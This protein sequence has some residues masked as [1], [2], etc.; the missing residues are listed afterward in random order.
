VPA[1]CK[2]A[3][4]SVDELI[5]TFSECEVHEIDVHESGNTFGRSYGLIRTDRDAI[6]WG[7]PN[8]LPGLAE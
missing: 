8:C 1:D 3:L 4:K 6:I 5:D 7:E 2:I